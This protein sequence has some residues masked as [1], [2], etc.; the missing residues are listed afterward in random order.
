M[1]LRYTKRKKDGKDYRY[2]SIV[3]NRRVG[4][5]RVVQRPLLYL[6]EINDSQE[7]ACRIRQAPCCSARPQPVWLRKN[8][9]LGPLDPSNRQS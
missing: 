3:K 5:G 2:S 7:L 4:G 6:D 1:F 9:R 8:K